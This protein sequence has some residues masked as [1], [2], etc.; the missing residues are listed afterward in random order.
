MTEKVSFQLGFKNTNSAGAS[1]VKWY[2]VFQ[3]FRAAQVKERSPSVVFD[4]KRGKVGKS[5]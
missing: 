5:S 1:Y 3:S 2:S 4:L